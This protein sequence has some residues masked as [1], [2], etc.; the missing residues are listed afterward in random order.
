MTLTSQSPKNDTPN[1][2]GKSITTFFQTHPIALILLAATAVFTFRLGHEGLWV[3]E[4]FSVRDAS[5]DSLAG[6][7]AASTVRPLYYFILHFWMGVSTHD[8]WLRSLSVIAALVAVFLIYR[9]GRRLAG[10][11]E[12]LIAAALLATSPLFVNHTQ[13]VRMYALSLCLGLAGTLFLAHALLGQTEEV[14]QT[15]PT[16]LSIRPHSPSRKTIIG[17]VVF[18]LLAILTV[19]LNLTLLIPDALLVLFRFRRQPK[20]LL[21]FTAAFISI[22][23]LW[24]PIVFTLLGV[25]DPSSDYAAER[26]DFAAAPGLNNLV[27]PLKFWMVLPFVTNL[28][29][30]A[31]NFYRLFTLLIAGLVGAGLLYKRRAAALPWTC[32]W[33]ILPLIPI[34]AFSLLSARIW[35]PRYVLFVSPYLFILTAAGFARLWKHWKTAAIVT[36]LTYVLGIGVALGHYYTIQNRGDYR[37][38]LETI[39]ANEQPGDA[40]FWSYPRDMALDHYYDGNADIF[41]NSGRD[42]DSP[43]T[44]RQ[45]LSEFPSTYERAWLVIEKGRKVEEF[46]A[47]VVSE[48]Y[49]IEQQFEYGH[50]SYVLLVTPKVSP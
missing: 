15:A 17:W 11:T 40:L 28:G 33:F 29:P 27:Y 20:E 10:E 41:S 13:E 9:L 34:I 46:F 30:V 47:D 32:A 23:L 21:R 6:V 16:E 48:T 14:A 45:W 25:L 24:S 22:L 4:L 1:T 8:V 49:N 43:E 36:T 42:V 39:E 19:P 5:Y 44:M 12:G 3:D 7:Y 26:A 18:R 50:N 38:N 35:E 37:F 2:I 31:H